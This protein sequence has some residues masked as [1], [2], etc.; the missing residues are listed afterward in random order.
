MSGHLSRDWNKK[1][2]HESPGG[3]G[4]VLE[5][6][7]SQTHSYQKIM[8][9]MTKILI[10]YHSQTGRTERMAGAVAEGAAS[11]QIKR[12]DQSIFFIKYTLI[13]FTV[14]PLPK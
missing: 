5:T 2:E 4:V 14:K 11:R 8:D 12:I 10:I 7:V 1:Q 3:T 6:G 13:S 9:I